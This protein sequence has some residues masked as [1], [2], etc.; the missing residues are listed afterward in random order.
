MFSD[1]YSANPSTTGILLLNTTTSG[2][3]DSPSDVDW[4]KFH[5]DA[6]QHY[7][8]QQI[9]RDAW[10]TTLSG[11][12]V[13][14]VRGVAVASS[15]LPFEP[16][17]SGDYFVGLSADY[18]GKYSVVLT[19]VNDDYSA[20]DS[21]PGQLA[22]GETVTGQIQFYGDSDRFHFTATAGNIYQFMLDASGFNG[23]YNSSMLITD[24]YGKSVSMPALEVVDGK[25]IATF[26]P[27][28]TGNY[29]LN[30]ACN[31]ETENYSLS[32]TVRADDYGGTRA[33]AAVLEIGSTLSGTVQVP[34]DVDMFQV[35]LFAGTTYQLDLTQQGGAQYNYQQLELDGPDG[36]PV[37]NPGLSGRHAFSYTPSVTGIYTLAVNDTVQAPSAYTISVTLAPDDY[38]ATLATAGALAVDGAALAG[39]LDTGGGDRD[40]F[41]LSLDAGQTYWARLMYPA[42]S[43][44]GL[45][46]TV[47]K[48]IDPSGKVLA[49]TAGMNPS[50]ATGYI[51]PIVPS[52]R[53]VYT[54]EVS[55]GQDS[56]KV[57]YQVKVQHGTVDDVGNDPA[58]AAPL[59][60]DTQTAGKLELPTDRDA[61]KL[62]VEAG[63]VYRFEVHGTDADVAWKNSVTLDGR[64]SSNDT[65]SFNQLLN[66]YSRQDV[67]YR[68]SS[69][70]D[71]YLL[72]GQ[73]SYNAVQTG[74]YSLHA[75]SY[76]KDDNPQDY[77]KLPQLSVGAQAPGSID[78]PGDS[79]SFT[80]HLEGGRSYVFELAGAL[81]GAGSLDATTATLAL[82]PTASLPSATV[83]KL[84]GGE[85]RLS[86][87]PGVSGDYH[88]SVTGD[89]SHLGSYVL[90]AVQTS[91]D[92]SAPVLASSPE[93]YLEGLAATCGLQFSEGVMPGSNG[94]T[95]KDSS[96]V[97]FAPHGAHSYKITSAGNQIFI[98]AN[99]YFSPGE[100]YTLTLPQDSV[101]DLAGNQLS[102]PLTIRLHTIAAASAGGSGDDLLVGHL[103]GAHIDGGSGIDTVYYARSGYQFDVARNQGDIT[104]HGAG[105]PRSDVLTGVERLLFQDGALALDMDGHAGQV[106]RLYQAAFNRAPD[107]AGLGYWIAAMDQGFTLQ[108][109]AHNFGASAEFVALY[110]TTLSDAQ[111]VDQLYHNVLHR[112]GDAAG[113][114]YWTNALAQEPQR[115]LVLV[116]FS[117]SA[118]NQ[119]SL[120]GRIEHGINYIPYG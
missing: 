2:T 70:G 57:A 20:N 11:F 79:D 104:V 88:V 63:N 27:G 21:S 10:A 101:L 43:F 108:A 98:D 22:P 74:S 117:E 40:W 72:V 71:I 26:I 61:Y 6:G 93:L 68:A 3:I 86:C 64:D 97:L 58:H 44:G 84:S 100:T 35:R 96:G 80:V 120:L 41:T 33:T 55:G 85:A 99:G 1:D 16:T 116:A 31:S 50:D 4:L 34:G 53:G 111:Y 24:Q 81:S 32:E 18:P 109:L 118:E 103:N 47:M 29:A 92:L 115:D 13:Y 60:L 5:A 48:V 76:G 67:L 77:T 75:H 46:G 52:G 28:T 7:T 8:F 119:A 9:G 62:H 42:G 87:V 66:G 106:Y 17:V 12:Q 69:T 49:T 95:L 89:L 90:R 83:S 59:A 78:Y 54:L 56:S 65:L 19:V 39:T 107:A 38:G 110:G 51:V 45:G 105:D 114:T 14:D 23:A 82:Y 112:A 37:D 36:R 25:L 94:I 113:I 15:G 102:A 30:L 91:G 73:Q